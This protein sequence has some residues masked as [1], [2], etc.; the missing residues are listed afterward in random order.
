MKTQSGKS[1]YHK[2]G[3]SHCS[4]IQGS[5]EQGEKWSNGG[6]K[7]KEFCREEGDSSGIA[8]W[9]CTEKTIVRLYFLGKYSLVRAQSNN[10]HKSW[11]EKKKT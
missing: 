10:R 11:L 4:L 1:G 8:W 6:R 5:R 7:N 3:V 2:S 9:R